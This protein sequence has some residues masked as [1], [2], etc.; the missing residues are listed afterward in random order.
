MKQPRHKLI[1]AAGAVLMAAVSACGSG[2]TSSPTPT[3]SSTAPAQKEAGATTPTPTPTAEATPTASASASCAAGGACKI[4]DT[5]PGGGIVFY[6]SANYR[7]EAAPSDQGVAK[8]GCEGTLIP[9]A[10]KGIRSGR[11]N[12]ED[13][14]VFCPQP[15]I[16]ASAAK[17]H[18]GGGKSDWFLPSKDA[19]DELYRVTGGVGGFAPDDCWSS[20]QHGP[21]YAWGQVFGE[22]RQGLGHKNATGNVRPVRAF[23]VR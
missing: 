20:S 17:S 23:Q 6:L 12:T 2:A 14:I 1:V 9:D 19:L 22:G 18:N 11:S 7:L 8:W 5:G 21:N 3:Q 16:A 10:D 4:G 13:I 15:G